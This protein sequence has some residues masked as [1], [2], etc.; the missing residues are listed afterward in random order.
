MEIMAEN[1]EILMSP[2][3]GFHELRFIQMEICIQVLD[4]K[5]K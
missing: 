4:E 1:K 2:R 5:W 3:D